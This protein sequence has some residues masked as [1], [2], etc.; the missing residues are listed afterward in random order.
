MLMQ[1]QKVTQDLAKQ[2]NK[3]LI[4]K[5]IYDEEPLS[6][7]DIARST[8]LTRTTVSNVVSELME[9]GLVQESGQAP[10]GGGKPPTLLQ[11]IP[12]AR[13]VI[14]V[15]LSG[16]ELRGTVYDLR[17]EALHQL[18]M[19]L[20]AE[21]GQ[22]VLEDLYQLLEQLADKA[23]A[24]LLGIGIGTPGLVN[25]Q[26]GIIHVAVH[27]NWEDVPLRQLLEERFQLPVYV[28]NDS[29]AA[30]LAQHTFDNEAAVNDIAVVKVGRGISAG[31]I[32]NGQLHHGGNNSGASEIG[33]V[34]VVEGGELCA[35]GHFG[36][37]ETVAGNKAVLRWA[38][39][40]AQTNPQAT[41][42]A[43]Q[44]LTIEEVIQA[45]HAG[46]QTLKPVI[47]QVGRYLG[48]SVVNLV[49]IL[50]IPQIVLA[51]DI[52]RFGEDLLPPL[53]Q[54]IT[55]RTLPAIAAKTKV[56]LSAL[57][58]DIVMQGAA[59]LLLTNELRVI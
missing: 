55:S 5:T 1:P 34:R 45:Y 59:A 31:I 20:L 57:G 16:E 28:V 58:S 3:R 49:T 54:E 26:E 56:R 37:L 23:A 7:A 33:H 18:T 14:G 15:D 35:C 21:T 25:A 36:C 13:N 19:P 9:E 4:L 11:M 6:R 51:G 10:S 12:D 2:H 17:G 48:I 29:Q 52:A 42:P 40:I 22:D 43:D 24:P 32:L 47:E 46:D 41:L 8:K 53:Q 27:L 44:P 30:A 38:N 50:N 39:M